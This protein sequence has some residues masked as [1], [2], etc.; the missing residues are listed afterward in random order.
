MMMAWVDA[1]RWL[2]EL[3]EAE[4]GKPFASERLRSGHC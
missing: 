1:L 2:I 3:L 4:A